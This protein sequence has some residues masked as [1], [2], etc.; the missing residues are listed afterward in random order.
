[1]FFIIAL[2][3][4]RAYK[5][6]SDSRELVA[7]HTKRLRAPLRFPMYPDPG[8]LLFVQVSGEGWTW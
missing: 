7:S 6:H 8:E 5:I 1:M 4:V 3:F 2:Q